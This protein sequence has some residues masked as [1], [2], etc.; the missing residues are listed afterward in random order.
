MAMLAELLPP[1]QVERLRELGSDEMDPAGLSRDELRAELTAR[2]A[3][4]ASISDQL[5][6]D[7]TNGYR[8]GHVARHALGAERTEASREARLL[9]SE[10]RNRDLRQREQERQQQAEKEA[11]NDPRPGWQRDIERQ[12]QA[13]KA[14]RQ[15][16]RAAVH[17]ARMQAVAPAQATQDRL[18]IQAVRSELGKQRFT[19]LWQRAREMFPHD[20]AWER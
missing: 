10:L 14:A 20:P 1:E 13:D 19:E 4:G 5:D 9:R 18:F 3:L 2:T 6:E 17:E 11:R 12:Q 7:A 15:A 16:E 8:M